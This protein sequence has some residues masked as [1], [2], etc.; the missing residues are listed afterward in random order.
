MRCAWTTSP[1]L[2]S[3]ASGY[4]QRGQD[5][6]GPAVLGSTEGGPAALESF[7]RAEAGARRAHAGAER[8]IRI[9][10]SIASGQ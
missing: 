2:S 10:A 3:S 7:A 5:L 4:K 6:D 9:D 1:S 8:H